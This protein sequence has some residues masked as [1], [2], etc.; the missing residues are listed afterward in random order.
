VPGADGGTAVSRA[1]NHRGVWKAAASKYA[2]PQLAGE[3]QVL[4]RGRRLLL[5]PIGFVA[6]GVAAQEFSV[7]AI[8][9][10]LFM[11][12]DYPLGWNVA[13]ECRVPGSF[14]A[15]DLK[16]GEEYVE[17]YMQALVGAINSTVYPYFVEI[18]TPEGYY[19][20]CRRKNI[21]HPNG[22]GDVHLLYRQAAAAIV[23]RRFRDA[24]EALD[25]LRKVVESDPDDDREWVMNLHEQAGALRDRVVAD[26]VAVR[27]ELILGM[28][29]Q[30]RRLNLPLTG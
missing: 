3:W 16:L 30:K 13:T 5:R 28:D 26:A 11:P 10:P 17:E 21:A 8:L 9:A 22:V 14:P 19:E 29:E 6:R 7:V 2:I 23:L 12:L 1:A 15:R 18:G 24:V 27:E 4:G 20:R 25:K